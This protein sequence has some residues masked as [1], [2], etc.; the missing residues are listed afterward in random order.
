[1]NDDTITSEAVREDGLASLDVTSPQQQ[2]QKL[3][4][5]GEE[6]DDVDDEGE[7]ENLEKD[8]ARELTNSI[9]HDNKISSNEISLDFTLSDPTKDERLSSID[10]DD[11]LEDDEQD[12]EGEGM[13]TVH[14]S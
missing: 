4:D 5:D 12:A 6:E 3:G 8:Q 11:E 13:W 9:E 2:G 7:E 1:M 14:I 10:E